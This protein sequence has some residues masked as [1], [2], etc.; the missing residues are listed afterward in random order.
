[1]NLRNF[2]LN[3]SFLIKLNNSF[4]LISEPLLL[5]SSF[6]QL[7]S[8]RIKQEK[9]LRIKLNNRKGLKIM[10]NNDIINF[11]QTYQR[12]TEHM[13]RE[14]PKNSSIIFNLNSKHQIKSIKFKK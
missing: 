11:M 10:S 13:F 6:T 7:Q 4:F 12:I 14:T 8:W 1:M 2:V 5:I 9:K 3:S